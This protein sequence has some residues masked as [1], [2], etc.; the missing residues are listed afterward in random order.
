MGIPDILLLVALYA[1]STIVT[2]GLLVVS[3]R[4]ILHPLRY[5]PGPFLARVTDGYAGYHAAK[6]RL[7]LAIYHDIAKYGTPIYLS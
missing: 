4:L 1:F 2:L 5:Y 6:K 7:H 3:Y